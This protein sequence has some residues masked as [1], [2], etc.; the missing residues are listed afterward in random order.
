MRKTNVASPDFP[1][2]RI[3]NNC[4]KK[5]KL[6]VDYFTGEKKRFPELKL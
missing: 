2:G 4:I 5:K 1:I 6:I 3:N